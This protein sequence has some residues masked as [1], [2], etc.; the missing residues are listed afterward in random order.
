MPAAVVATR[1]SELVRPRSH[2]AFAIPVG[3]AR[4]RRARARAVRAPPRTSGRSAVQAGCALAACG[5]VLGLVGALR[6]RLPAAIAVGFYGAAHATS[7]RAERDPVRGRGCLYIG[8]S[9]SRSARACAR[10]APARASSSTRWRPARRSARST[11]ACSRRSGSTSSRRTR[12]QGLPADVRGLARPR[13]AALRRRVQLALRRR[14]GGP[15]RT[16]D[17]PRAG[18]AA[19]RASERRESHRRRDRAGGDRAR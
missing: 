17:T 1:Y 14:R 13:R 16:R 4:H 2:A 7:R 6:S 5:R 19:P 10:P 15:P 12:T 8:R 11:C 3:L 9:C 18:G